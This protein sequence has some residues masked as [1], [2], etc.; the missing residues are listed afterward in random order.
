MVDAAIGHPR[1]QKELPE[2]VRLATSSAIERQLEL[3]TLGSKWFTST[4]LLRFESSKTPM[5][6]W[7]RLTSVAD[8]CVLDICICSD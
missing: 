8:P 1:S 7:T 2:A 5:R 3:E 6:L 4:G